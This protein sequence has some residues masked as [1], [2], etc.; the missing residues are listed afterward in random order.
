MPALIRVSVVLLAAAAL[1]ACGGGGGG[2]V[3][4][5]VANGALPNDPSQEEDTE[6]GG[7]PDFVITSV[8]ASSDT[9][10]QFHIKVTIEN[11]G[12]GTGPIP[13]AWFVT[14]AEQLPSVNYHHI[15]LSWRSEDGEDIDSLAPGESIELSAGAYGMVGDVYFLPEQDGLHY[16]QVW[17]NPDLSLRYANPEDRV[18][19][20]HEIEELDYTNNQSEVFTYQAVPSGNYFH[21]CE[22]D[23]HEPN[24]STDSPAFIDVGV[25]YSADTC[26]DDIDVFAVQMEAGQSY[27][28]KQSDEEVYFTV[29]GPDM[30]YVARSLSSYIGDLMTAETSGVH[31]IVVSRENAWGRLLD[32]YDFTV[33]ELQ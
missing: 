11:N 22:P 15:P 31:H 5:G 21:T 20:S 32:E 16:G 2:G 4:A 17:L 8:A 6:E 7:V 18:E 26:D 3:P 19:T 25:T 29:I 28:L 23:R 24:D 30:R 33:I 14:S 27:Q 9:S 12:T 13:G 10:A 1:S